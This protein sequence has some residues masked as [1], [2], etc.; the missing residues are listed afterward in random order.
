MKGR[1]LIWF[2]IIVIISLLAS[3]FLFD[4]RFDMYSDLITL[5]SILIG[6][7]IT[8]LS[9]LFNSPLKR[10]LYDRKIKK[11]KTELHRL[12]DFYRF[13]LIIELV[14]I[15][16]I[17]IVPNFSLEIWNIHLGK[18]VIILPILAS[19]IYCFYKICGDLFQIFVY[20]VND[21]REK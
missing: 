18:N 21:S 2:I 1:D 11:Y 6:F 13:T 7:E 4:N 19:S 17:F 10:T 12:R 5:L 9:I 16:I 3:V 20:P 15:C 14:N 8:S